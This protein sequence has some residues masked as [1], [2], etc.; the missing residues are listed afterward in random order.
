M[1]I[2][3][4]RDARFVFRQSAASI[5]FQNACGILLTS[6]G[7]FARGRS[8]SDESQSLFNEASKVVQL[9]AKVQELSHE[10]LNSEDVPVD[11]TSRHRGRVHY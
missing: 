2:S 9:E 4:P 6:R 1:S 10:N 5:C 3:I 8:V 7:I 11:G